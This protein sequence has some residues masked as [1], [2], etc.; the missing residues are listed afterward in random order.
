MSVRV[1]WTAHAITR[2][3]DIADYVAQHD[4]AAAL[5]LTGHIFDATQLLSEN[6]W[7]APGLFSGGESPIRRLVVGKHLVIYRVQP[8]NRS[9]WILTVRHAREAPVQPGDL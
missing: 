2:L 5:R 7:I 3:Q 4:S 6:P 9:L 8:D 1:H